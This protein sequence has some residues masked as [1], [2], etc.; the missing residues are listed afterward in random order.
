MYRRKKMHKVKTEVQL[1]AFTHI[2]KETTSVNKFFKDTVAE[3]AVRTK[4]MSLKLREKTK[5]QI[6]MN[7]VM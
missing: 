7:T 1:S 3:G 6:N 5:D 4:I 2:D